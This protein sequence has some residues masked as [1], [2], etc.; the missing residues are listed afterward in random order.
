MPGHRPEGS[1]VKERLKRGSLFVVSAP[2]G[3]GKTSL[4]RKLMSIMP[5]ITHSVSYT[6]REPRKGEVNDQDYTFVDEKRFTEMS[7][8]GEFAEWARVHGNLYGTSRQ[9]LRE[10]MEAGHSVILDIDTEGARQLRESYP[11]GVF[12][13]ILPPSI[14]ALRERLQ[15]R[16][17]DSTVEIKARIRRAAAEI[18]D[19]KNYDYV[20][21]N[22]IFESALRELE[23]IVV[24]K[25]LKVVDMNDLWVEDN[26]LR[27]E[28]F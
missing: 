26:F 9:R 18:K 21:V 24:T 5:G 12:I 4:C 14:A 25:G 7:G 2:S 20:I 13:F 16:M 11:D 1:G 19:Y 8:A 28:D 15:G 22:N 6:T 17:S 3:A 23:A 10:T 27:Q